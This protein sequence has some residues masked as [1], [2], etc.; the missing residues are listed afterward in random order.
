VE[1]TEIFYVDYHV[2][3]SSLTTLKKESSCKVACLL[4]LFAYSFWDLRVAIESKVEF[5]STKKKG[6]VLKC[7]QKNPQSSFMSRFPLFI[8]FLSISLN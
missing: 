3:L 1:R 5:V 7:G 6:C 2:V 8:L 4:L